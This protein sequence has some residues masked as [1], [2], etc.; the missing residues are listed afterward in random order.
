MTINLEH[1][2]YNFKILRPS[3]SIQNICRYD[4]YSSYTTYSCI[5]LKN[6]MQKLIAAEKCIT[7]L[8]FQS[9]RRVCKMEWEAVYLKAANRIY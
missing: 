5:Q 2:N 7:N 3:I 4:Y 6:I 1:P 8:I 9:C